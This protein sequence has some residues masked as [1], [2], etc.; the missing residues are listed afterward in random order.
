MDVSSNAG[1]AAGFERARTFGQID[2][3]VNNAG[4]L[5][6]GPALEAPREGWDELFAINVAGAFFVSQ[7]AAQGWIAQ[8]RGGVIVNMC[9]TSGVSGRPGAIAYSASKAALA[10][11]TRV[12][13]VEWAP[14]G[15]RVNGVAPGTT[16]T[17][18]RSALLD[19]NPA[20]KAEMVSRIP[21]KRLGQ[22]SDVAEAVRWLASAAAAYVSGVV[23]PVDGALLAQ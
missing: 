17:K 23:L 16:A 4:R 5:L 12:L 3:V 2:I 9:S 1:I 13:A 11:I 18:T 20:L 14:Y 19:A 7:A 10:Q 15:I 22:A 21:A 8:S 6:A